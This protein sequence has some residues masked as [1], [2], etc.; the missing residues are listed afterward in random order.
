MTSAESKKAFFRQSTWMMTATVASGA[1]MYFVHPLVRVIPDGD[2]ATFTSLLQLFVWLGIPAVGLQMIF[3]QLA[4]SAVTE[5]KQ[6][7]LTGAARVVLGWITLAWVMLAATLML[8]GKRIA[9]A[10]SLESPAAIWLT[11]LMGLVALWAPLLNGLLQGAQNFLWIGWKEIAN[12]LGRLIGT[13]VIV[14]HVS[15]TAL[16]ALTAAM[17]ALFVSL[18]LL[19]WQCRSVL[20]GQAES[21]D[22]IEWRRRWVGL[23]LGFG[24]FL[25]MMS[26]DAVILK[27]HFTDDRLAPYNGAGTLARAIV[28]FTA[29]LAAVM[30]PKIVH[31]LVHAQRTDALKLTFVG[32]ALL[33]V[34]A[35]TGLSILAPL[36]LGLGIRPSFA[37]SAPLL[38]WYAWAM[39]PLALANVLI[40]DLMARS[41]FVASPWLA[42]VAVGYGVTLM[43]HHESFK[44]VILI[45]GSFNTLLFVVAA[46]FT[47]Q[48]R[49]SKS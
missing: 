20:L 40:S 9:S 37:S 44:Q 10:W 19:L 43:F 27:A 28:T 49:A 46:F 32:A 18:I 2:Y 48:R 8:L 16:G 39:V 25:F 35:A 5:Q 42:L 1:C 14:Y 3:A 34:L 17:L 31:S 7:Q 33:S 11:L 36:A 24:A 15:A 6:R 26:A 45:L 22:W 23:T 21:F 41:R 29:P 47:W 38:P 12:G 4:A 13:Y 30:F